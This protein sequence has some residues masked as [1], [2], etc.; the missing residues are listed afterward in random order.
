M[1]PAGFITTFKRARHLS[2]FWIRSIQSIP[3]SHFL[4]IDFSIILPLFGSSMWFL[5]LR[6]PHL[7]HSCTSPFPHTYN[8]PCQSHSSWFYHPN[9]IWRWVRIIKL[10]V[11]YSSPLPCHVVHFRPEYHPQRPILKHPQPTFLPQYK[12]PSFT[13]IQNK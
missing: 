2:I 4:K 3:P 11:T 8:M 5:S 9:N 13:L 6:F 10:I 7:N 12:R 1:E